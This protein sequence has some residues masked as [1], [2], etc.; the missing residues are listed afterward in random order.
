[1][2]NNILL[3]FVVPFY[4]VESYIE[5]CIHSLFKQDIPTDLYEVILIDDSS[6]DSSRRIVLELKEK[7]PKII[8]LDNIQNKKIGGARNIGFNHASGEYIWFVDSDDYIKP[9]V[10]KKLLNVALENNLDVLHF[11]YTRVFSDGKFE[12]YLS[13]YSTNVIDGNTFFF[14]EGEIWW[15]KN[16]EVWR[17]LHKRTFIL[18][19]M[20]KHEESIY[21]SEDVIYSIYVFNKA[22]RVMHISESPYYYRLNP[23]SFLNSPDTGFKLF[24]IVS[25][26]LHLI[27][28]YE[29]DLLDK[30]YVPLIKDLIK[31]HFKEVRKNL[32]LINKIEQDFFFKEIESLPLK[33]LKRILKWN[34][35]WFF[36][37]SYL[38]KIIFKYERIKI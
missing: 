23:N 15:K 18:H 5:E 22:K 2:M 26:S 33:K 13:N 34:D 20:I 36:K 4:N 27:D 10:L 11:D 37:N 14:N 6:N 32:S 35:Y 3:S 17:R 29:N 28:L 31:F 16:V 24:G 1:M 21:I 38:R 19:N 25:S 8:L 7:Y 9:N 12:K 30:R